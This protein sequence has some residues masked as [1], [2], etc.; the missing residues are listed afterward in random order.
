MKYNLTYEHFVYE[1]TYE[2]LTNV[3]TFVNFNIDFLKKMIDVC[4]R[5]K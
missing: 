2:D 3:I 5:L 1:V 4:I